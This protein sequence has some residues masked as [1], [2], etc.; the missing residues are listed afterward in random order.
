MVVIIIFFGCSGQNNQLA[1]IRRDLEFFFD[2][3]FFGPLF[4]GGGWSGVPDFFLHI[5]S[6]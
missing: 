6:S 3:Q 1:M 4:R 2:S 5:S